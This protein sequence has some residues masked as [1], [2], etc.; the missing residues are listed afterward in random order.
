MFKFISLKK[1]TKVQHFIKQEGKNISSQRNNSLKII[2]K[3]AKEFYF[4]LSDD[5]SS[6]IWVL[7][8]PK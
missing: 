6:N 2:S 7:F 5:S 3:K 1:N 8:F 4:I